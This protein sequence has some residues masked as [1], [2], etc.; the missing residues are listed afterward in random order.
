MVAVPPM[1]VSAIG[2][3]VSRSALRIVPTLAP[4]TACLSRPHVPATCGA[5]IDV[6]LSDWNAPPGTDDVIDSPGANSERN[7]AA[8][9]NHE[10]T[11]DLSVDP[12]LTADET[13]A[14]VEMADVAE[15]FPAA[16]TVATPI[17]RRLSMI[18]LY[19]SLSQGAVNV[20]PPRLMFTDTTLSAGAMAYTRSRPAM[21]SDVNAPMHGA[22]PP[23]LKGF[24]TSENTW[25]AI[26]SASGAT[27]ENGTPAPAPFPAAMPATWV[28]WMQS[29]SAHGTADPGPI[30]E[31]RPFGHTDRLRPATVLE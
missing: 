28:P 1:R 20:V 22:I 19:G 12:T 5:A 31:V 17:D 11:F 16:T 3:P 4:G 9:E 10:T 23:Q 2:N 24:V 18:G 25:T 27:P 13:Q 15:L 30:C 21:M 14:G 8:F 7:D 6:P 26:S 29:G